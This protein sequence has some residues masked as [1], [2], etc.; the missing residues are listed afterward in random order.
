M[1]S[2]VP[3]PSAATGSTAFSTH[4]KHDYKTLEQH[5]LPIGRSRSREFVTGIG[6]FRAGLS[7][8]NPG[9]PFFEPNSEM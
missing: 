9:Q 1:N 6:R 7:P 5:L 3:A 4:G 2:L 8:A